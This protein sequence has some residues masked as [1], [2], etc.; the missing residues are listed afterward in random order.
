MSHEIV[1]YSVLSLL[2]RELS[3]FAGFDM[4]DIGDPRNF[5]FVPTFAIVNL[6]VDVPCFLILIITWFLTMTP[7]R[8]I[9]T[10]HVGPK[11]IP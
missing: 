6:A 7:S 11:N 5:D 9:G 10:R 3:F 1:C 4:S 8:T 2:R